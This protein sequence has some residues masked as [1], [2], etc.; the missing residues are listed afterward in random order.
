MNPC[1]LDFLPR[2]VEPLRS[3]EAEHVALA[4]VLADERRRESEASA[5]LQI[6]RELEHGAGN[7]C[8][9]S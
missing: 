5:G 8:T 4:A 1:A 9:S 3:D 7:R 6:G 2:G